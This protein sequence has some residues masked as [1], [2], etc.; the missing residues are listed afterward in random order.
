MRRGMKRLRR[1]RR[2]GYTSGMSSTA[3]NPLLLAAAHFAAVKHRAQRRKGAS[4]DPYINHPIEAADLLARVGGVRDAA[5]LAAA[6]LHDTIE[7][8]GTTPDELRD[9]F[10]QTVLSIVLEVT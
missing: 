6:L 8:T 9:C 5:T 3:E 10:G 7:D 1:L 4:A 2:C